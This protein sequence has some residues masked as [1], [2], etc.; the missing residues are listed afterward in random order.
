MSLAHKVERCIL[1]RPLKH[2]AGPANVIAATAAVT[3]HSDP[4]FCLPSFLLLLFVDKF[5]LVRT[6]TQKKVRLHH[7]LT[8]SFFLL[9]CLFGN[10]REGAVV[11]DGTGF[12]STIGPYH[13]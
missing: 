12:K 13:E 5:V 6:L 4:S 11:L 8:F 1:F 10:T 7:S 9:A 2:I 3:L